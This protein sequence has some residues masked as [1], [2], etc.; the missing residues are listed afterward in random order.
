MAR[1]GN[2]FGSGAQRGFALLVVLWTLALL[3]LIGVVIGASGRSEARIARNLVD[4]AE[5]EAALEGA[6]QEAGLR[7]LQAGAAGWRADGEARQVLIGNR[8]V[9]VRIRDAADMLNP[10]TA[11][12]PALQALLRSIGVAPGQSIQ[13]AQAIVDWRGGEG[14]QPRAMA[15]APYVDLGLPY[16]PP[17]APFSDAGEI[18]LVAGMTPEIVAA[19][20]PHLSLANAAPAVA[21]EDSEPAV[22]QAL[23]GLPPAVG[24][25]AQ[26]R[27]KAGPAGPGLYIIRVATLS[28]P[29]LSRRVTVQVGCGTGAL[30]CLRILEWA[31]GP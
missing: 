4:A 30:T 18:A 6:V 2:G 17:Q 23:G 20:T 25:G 24:M 14:A 5:A 29:A 13:L 3:S 16:G 1:G 22:R 27:A 8:M 15:A 11:S 10:N 28:A 19:L 26:A 7:L 31:R 9:Q 21:M 12:L